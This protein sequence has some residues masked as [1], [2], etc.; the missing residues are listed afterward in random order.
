MLH[1]LPGFSWSVALCAWL[2]SVSLTW[3]GPP[4]TTAITRLQ[5]YLDNHHFSPGP[6]D[7]HYGTFTKRALAYYN[8]RE[9]RSPLDW[10]TVLSKAERE[11]PFVVV[12]HRLQRS[13]WKW[14][15]DVPD[16]LAAQAKQTSLP[17]TSIKEYLAERY[18][19]TVPFL[20]RLNRRKDLDFLQPGD[21]V[22]VPNVKDVFRIE[23]VRALRRPRGQVQT[24]R[25]V[26]VDTANRMASICRGTTLLA[27]FPITHG[28]ER[29]VPRGQWKVQ[30][31]VANPSF[32]WDERMLKE[33]ERSTDFH[34][35]PPGPNNPVGVLWMGISKKGIGLHGTNAPE[36]IGRS[37]SAGCVRFTNWDA[38]R[39]PKY[40]GVGSEVIVR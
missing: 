33:G 6:I 7:G 5:I 24:E 4:N 22:V 31:L 19:A 11:I 15:G 26:F 21:L 16:D 3:A 2:L 28:R 13:E 39:L 27:A 34:T 9:G 18:H 32:R 36:T 38:M 14:V 37:L 12:T 30:N 23:A 25:Y 17:Y 1:Y 40:L 35:L 8:T 20:Q 29:F 10:Q